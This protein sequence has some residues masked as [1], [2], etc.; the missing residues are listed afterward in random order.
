M[1][2]Y[3]LDRS[4]IVPLLKKYATSKQPIPIQLIRELILGKSWT[5]VPTTSLRKHSEL[6]KREIFAGILEKSKSKEIKEE[7]ELVQSEL[8]EAFKARQ[9]CERELPN[10]HGH[11]RKFFK[12]LLIDTDEEYCEARMGD[13]GRWTK[14]IDK[15]GGVQYRGGGAYLDFVN[16]RLDFARF[17][18]KALLE[19]KSDAL[20]M[21]K[22]DPKA[23][24][25]KRDYDVKKYKREGSFLF[26][27]GNLCS[28]HN[29]IE[30]EK[31][32]KAV[33]NF[34]NYSVPGGGS[35]RDY[36]DKIIV[37]LIDTTEEPVKGELTLTRKVTAMRDFIAACQVKFGLP[38]DET[39]QVIQYVH[40][41]K[42]SRELS[43]TLRKI[44]TRVKQKRWK[45]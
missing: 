18:G 35:G 22:C 2:T 15:S 27:D 28:A 29:D 20:L 10:R 38:V 33:I 44:M 17:F 32:K 41:S 39:F 34:L 31:V 4:D 14:E 6:F 42:N 36:L 7:I 24:D 13:S 8:E 11:S 45:F 25:F 21:L 26:L 43:N 5:S 23:K 12:P 1:F 9:A 3:R 30:M 19:A 37:Q 40:F 16:A